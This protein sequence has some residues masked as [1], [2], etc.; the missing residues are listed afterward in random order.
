LK[1]NYIKLGQGR[2]LLILHGLFGSLDNW[3][4]LGNKFAKNYE[5]YLIDQRNHGKS[6]HSDEFDYAAM[7]SDLLEFIEDHNLRAF[8][9]LG[10]SMG[11]KAVMNFAQECDLVDK[12]IVAD[13]APKIYAPHHTIIIE[14]LKNVDFTK[15]S[16]RNDVEQLLSEDIKE[17][18]IRQFLMKNLYWREKNVL[19][20]KINLDS[21]CKNLDQIIG[22]IDNNVVTIP[23]L[24]IRGQNSNYIKNEDFPQIKEQFPNS[25]IETIPNAGHWLHAEN[26]SLFYNLVVRFLDED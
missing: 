14:S 25:R 3:K 2:P 22:A 16:S 10:H 11:G 19:D 1:L 9:L 21:I 17:P 5:V 6:P 12:M 24:F 15:V 8:Y 18:A 4:T 13:I 26:P 23:T 7:S 20:W